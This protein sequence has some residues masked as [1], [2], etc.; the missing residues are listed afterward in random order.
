[1]VWL[2]CWSLILILLL[3]LWWV[4]L[5][6]Q[7]AIFVVEQLHVAREV[8]A[9]ALVRTLKYMISSLQR[10]GSKCLPMLLVWH[11]VATV[12]FVELVLVWYLRVRTAE[13]VRGLALGIASILSQLLLQ[14]RLPLAV[15]IF[16]IL[17]RLLGNTDKKVAHGL[18]PFKSVEIEDVALIGVVFEVFKQIQMRRGAPTHLAILVLPC[19]ILFKMLP[20]L[21]VDRV[22]VI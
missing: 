3:L 16:E 15:H 9:A 12:C 5:Y 6:L 20:R 8:R 7:I 10:L 2:K 19:C 22:V 18:V 13:E 17:L 1:M 21:V 4:D 11:R 14:L